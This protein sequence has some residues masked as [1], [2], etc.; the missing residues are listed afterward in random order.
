MF[1]DTRALR[2]CAG[3]LPWRGW[4]VLC[5]ALLLVGCGSDGEDGAAAAT[6]PIQSGTLIR[7]NDGMVQG[8]IDS[9]TR[10][11]LGIPFAAP[12]VGALRW[13]RPQ[14]VSPWSGVRDT[15]AFA[16]PCPQGASINGAPSTT[17]DCLYLNVWSPEPAPQKRLPVMVWIHGGGNTAGSAGDLVPLGVGGRFYDGHV[18]TQTRDVIVVSVNYR[19]GIFGFFANAALKSE[20]SA[21]PYAGN[22]G[23][24]DQRQA[25][26]WVRDNIAVFGGDPDNVTIFGESAGSWDVCAHVVSPGSRGLFHRAIGE[27]G[28]CTTHQ[29]TITDAAAASAQVS[30]AVGCADAANELSCLRQVPVSTLLSQDSGPGIIIDGGV[31]PDQ[32]RTLFNTGKFAKVPYILGSNADEGTLFFI[33]SR[34]VTTNAKYLEAL[35]QAYGDMSDEVAA[36]YPASAFRTPQ[37][38]LA[39][40]F[41]DSSLVCP[42]Y[43]VARRAAAGGSNVYLYNFARPIPIEAL[44]QFNLG[45]THGA[46]IAYVFGSVDPPLAVDAMLAQAMQGYWTR[47]ARNGDPNGEAAL[48]WPKYSAAAD[49]RINFDSSINIVPNFRRTECEFWWSVYDRDF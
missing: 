4:V 38:A 47:L 48:A 2:S 25:L 29:S 27:S 12:P 5:L 40:V 20:E 46:E 35:K 24:L 49:Q 28:G 17:E 30:A 31:L 3:S 1:A 44:A 45:A 15:T 8:S 41:G 26:Q 18:L 19:L 22:Q 9:G 23:L 21:Y 13:H 34:P 32:P 7:L 36:V 43:D 39:R 37:D 14:P 6:T 11:F 10:R 33:G 42:T 16:S